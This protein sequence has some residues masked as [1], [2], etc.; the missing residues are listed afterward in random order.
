MGNL[1]DERIMKQLSQRELGEVIGKDQKYISEVEFGRII[2]CFQK[3][4]TLARF[5]EVP[6]ERIFPCFTRTSRFPGYKDIMYLYSLGYDIGV[7]E[8]VLR[9]LTM[10]EAQND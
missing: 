8:N 3:A 9:E 1:R 6:V 4:D 10:K 2:P 7:Y 5:L